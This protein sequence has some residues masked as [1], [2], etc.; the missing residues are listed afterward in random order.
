MIK[1]TPNPTDTPTEEQIA[2][3]VEL[4]NKGISPLDIFSY[5]YLPLEWAI[6]QENIIKQAAYEQ[7]LL[8]NPETELPTE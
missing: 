7:W 2:T 5:H 8:D 6:E 3:I 4:L 1:I